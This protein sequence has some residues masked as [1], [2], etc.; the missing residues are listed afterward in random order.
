MRPGPFSFDPLAFQGSVGAELG[1]V[2]G[3]VRKAQSQR[4]AFALLKHLCF[5][6]SQCDPVASTGGT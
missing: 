5:L 1:R 3:I 6:V 4:R 2:Y